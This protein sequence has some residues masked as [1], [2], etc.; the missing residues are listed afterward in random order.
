MIKAQGGFPAGKNMSQT[1][2][3]IATYDFQREVEDA[4]H[5]LRRSGFDMRQLSIIGRDCRSGKGVVGYYCCG[6]RTQY[7]GE[8]GIFW[9][10]VWAQLTDSAFFAIPGLGPLLA[11]GP[12]VEWIAGALEGTAV[13]PGL[14]AVGA[15][16]Y[17]F[18]I[19]KNSVVWMETAL[20]A[21]RL[22][23]VAHGAASDSVR[24]REILQSAGATEVVIHTDQDFAASAST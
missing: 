21:G 24:A 4:I 1:T 8:A 19:P 12:L 14:S 16:F 9:G 15:G 13:I 7:C 11:A 10:G 3:V 2:A 17:S 6:G 23:V 18:R 5:K 22:L 20:R